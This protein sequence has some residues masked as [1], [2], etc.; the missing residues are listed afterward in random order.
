MQSNDGVQSLGIDDT[1]DLQMFS[2]GHTSGEKPS[3]MV[4]MHAC[5]YVVQYLARGSAHARVSMYLTWNVKH[6]N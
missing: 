4:D 1:D 5:V 2:L 6:A 3:A